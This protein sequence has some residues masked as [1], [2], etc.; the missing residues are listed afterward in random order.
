MNY[1]EY[2]HIQSQVERMYDFHPDFFDELDGVELEVLRKGFLYNTDD[3]TYPESLKQY[4]EDNVSTDEQLQKR[5]FA[6]VQK[7]YDLSGSGK[8]EDIIKSN[9]SFPEQ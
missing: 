3:D 2:L 4:Y 8:L 9:V 6:A 7:L 5:M 1:T